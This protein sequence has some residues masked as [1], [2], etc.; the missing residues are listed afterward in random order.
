MVTAH[1]ITPL[2]NDEPLMFSWRKMRP[3]PSVFKI[4]I[5]GLLSLFT[6]QE[7]SAEETN[8]RGIWYDVGGISLNPF[9]KRPKVPDAC[10][11][12]VITSHTCNY[13]GATISKYKR[14]DVSRVQIMVNN[15]PKQDLF[16]ID[17]WASGPNRAELGEFIDA[18]HNNGIQ[19]FLTIWV[20]PTDAYINSLLDSKS[21]LLDTVRAHHVEGVEVEDEEP[22]WSASVVGSNEIANLRTPA[23]AL[24]NGLRAN[25]PPGILIGVT[26]NFKGYPGSEVLREKFL[27]DDLIKMAD[28]ISLQAYQPPVSDKVDPTKLD[29][30]KTLGKEG[31]Y[32]PAQFVENA[33]KLFQKLPVKEGARL[34]LGLPTFG[35]L[36][37]PND[38]PM[39]SMYKAAITAMC[40]TQTFTPGNYI[41]ESYFSANNIME[42]EKKADVNQRDVLNAR[43]NEFLLQ[44]K[45]DEMALRCDEVGD[46]RPDIRNLCHL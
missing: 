16:K 21:V 41:G 24:M 39:Q 35:L 42:P 20:R 43:A 26:T 36:S 11:G 38:S 28:V 32:E 6:I 19:V 33:I 46:V 23:A 29:Y 44:C 1:C 7:T 31:E 22:I 40:R 13:L 9:P 17:N 8:T 4:F 3:V 12:V 10:R 5:L 30:S 27:Q 45:K 14:F 2:R 18:L 25:L 37:N 34:I 15:L